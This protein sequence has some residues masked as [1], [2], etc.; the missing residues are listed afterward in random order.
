MYH[1]LQNDNF[2]TLKKA[3]LT[4]LPHRPY[5]SDDLT[6]GV[7][8]RNTEHAL[9]M[10]HIQLSPPY[11]QTAIIIDVDQP[12]ALLA[13]EDNGNVPR[14]SWIAINPESTHA[15][16]VYLLKSP[17][18]RAEYNGSLKALRYAAAIEALL[19]HQ[20]SGDPLYGGLLT[21]NPIHPAWDTRYICEL[22]NLDGYE[23][24]ELSNADIIYYRPQTNTKRFERFEAFGL[25]RNCALFDDTR[26]WAYKAVLTFK[27]KRRS[28]NDWLKATTER[29]QHA[30]QLFPTPLAPNEATAIAKSIAKW[31][32]Y[33]FDI[34]ASN[35]RFSK[36]QSHRNSQ[37]KTYSGGK[38]NED[39]R[40]WVIENAT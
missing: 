36:L 38:R 16:Y 31:V 25:G 4:R 27:R 14:P 20:L 19:N 11:V 23:L 34:N 1:R 3:L 29:V 6:C 8:I 32:W 33:K 18:L 13:W 22:D 28:Y 2:E 21:H 17:I 7:K 26:L 30:N 9:K 10:R 24:E 15:H 35:H 12:H 5:C 37:R 40:K 39:I